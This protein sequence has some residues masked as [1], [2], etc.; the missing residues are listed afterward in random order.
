MLQKLVPDGSLI[1]GADDS[2]PPLRYVDD[3]GVYKGVIVDCMNPLSPELG[4][5]ILTIPYK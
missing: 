4:V 1:Y 5:E 2:S 3:D